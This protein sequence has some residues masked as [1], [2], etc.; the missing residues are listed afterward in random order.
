MHTHIFINVSNLGSMGR[1]SSR[2]LCFFFLFVCFAISAFTPRI[3]LLHSFNFSEDLR[4]SDTLVLNHTKILKNSM[5]NL[6]FLSTFPYCG[7]LSK[8]GR[9]V[10]CLLTSE[11]I[12]MFFY[13][14]LFMQPSGVGAIKVPGQ[15][16]RISHLQKA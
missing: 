13:I 8:E 7:F 2:I 5:T 6:P 12:G 10:E 14:E 15:S 4:I 1:R 3:L 9:L 11:W 16:V